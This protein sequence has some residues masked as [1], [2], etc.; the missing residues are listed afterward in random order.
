MKDRPS[1]RRVMIVAAAISICAC[2]FAYYAST[3]RYRHQ[4]WDHKPT[5]FEKASYWPLIPGILLAMAVVPTYDADAPH[6]APPS[7][8]YGL[9]IP[10]VAVVSTVFWTVLLS[11]LYVGFAYAARKLQGTQFI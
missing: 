5:L 10:M 2:S 7:P 8:L 11:L 3:T 9:V 6:E 4:K 1:I